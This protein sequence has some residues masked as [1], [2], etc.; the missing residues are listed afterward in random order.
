MTSAESRSTLSTADVYLPVTDTV[1]ASRVFDKA[2]LTK[3][4][5]LQ[6]FRQRVTPAARVAFDTGTAALASGDFAKAESSLKSALDTDNENAAVL[7]YL[8]AVFAA[9]GRDDQAAG[10][11]QTALVDGSDI[12]DIYEW[13]ADSL[14][15]MR[16]LA[17][18]QAVL[19]EATTK[20]P[21]DDR[22][23]KPMAI[24]YATFGQGQR[25]VRMLERYLEANGSDVEAL[26]LAVEW[27]YHLRLANIAAHSR[28]DDLKLART[29]ADAYAKAKGQ[30]Q[31][32]VRQWM[33][34]LEKN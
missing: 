27:L 13:L 16:R 30:Q 20:W 3:T 32:L 12:P 9:A 5:T 22:F 10:A 23:A 19:E 17:E 33:E 14:L 8:A 15:R 25:A 31:A 7:A 21:A 29:Y 2:G 34:Y 11:W 28:G 18:A 26:Q 4:D 24:V 1:F 6:A